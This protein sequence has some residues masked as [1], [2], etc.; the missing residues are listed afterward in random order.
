MCDTDANSDS[1]RAR[2]A[3][4][5]LESALKKIGR[6]DI[7]RTSIHRVEPVFEPTDRLLSSKQFKEWKP[8]DNGSMDVSYDE[9]DLSHVC[10]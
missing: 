7:I 5:A 10:L 9:R 6:E 4:N 3:G 1:N 8:T 2:F